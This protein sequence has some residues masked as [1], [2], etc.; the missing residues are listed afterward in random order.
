MTGIDFTVFKGSPNGKIVESKT[1]KESIKPDEVLLK[2]TH[3]GLCGTDQ[4]HKTSDMVL[5]HEGV[6]VVQQVGSQVTSFKIGDRA[7]WG[8]LHNSCG[9]CDECLNANEMFCPERAMYARSN[10]DQGAFASYAVWKA[11][12]I[13]HIPDAITSSDAAPLMCAG[14]TMFNAMYSYNV[15]PADR[16][17]IVGIGGLGHIAIQFAAKMGCDVVVFSGSGSKKEEAKGLGAREFYVTRG[18]SKLEIGKPIKHLFVTSSRIPDWN[19][20]L[21]VLAPNA[22]IYPTT[23]SDGNLTVPYLPLV[24]KGLTIQGSFC[25]SRGVHAKMLTFAAVHRIKPIT[26]EFPLTVEGIEEAMAKLDEGEIR[27]RAVLVA[28][29]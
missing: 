8:F 25:A 22:T 1:H 20:F 5:G 21:P 10:T 2:I 29:R 16:V 11:A 14:A 18:V 28:G 15:R 24:S 13:F 4:H 17:G 23:F 9:H 27:Y 26:E 7:G 19:L 12:F 6:G 3:A